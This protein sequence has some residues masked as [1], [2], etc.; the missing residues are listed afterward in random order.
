MTNK[1]KTFNNLIAGGIAGTISRTIVAPFD[2]VK[3][4]MQT[5][6][7]NSSFYNTFNSNI[8]NEGIKNLWKGNMLNCM[9]VFPYSALQFSTYDLCKKHLNK[10]NED[11]T[12]QERLLAGTLAGSIATTLTHPIDVVRHRLMCYDEIKT[13]RGAIKD[14]YKENGFKS[15]FKGYGSTML[16]LTPF[17]AINFATYDYLKSKYNNST[18]SISSIILTSSISSLTA[19][20]VCYPLDT[21]RRR[22]MSKD[23]LYKNS[24]DGLIKILSTEGVRSLY[25]GITVN[26][27][28]MI[29]NNCIRFI[30]Y[31][32][33]KNSNE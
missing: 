2:K 29:P 19:Q 4:L 18:N 26:M 20:S 21:I 31:E 6:T 32:S 3:I 23:F 24:L 33:I 12:I 11:I 1:E 13:S 22:M 16:G 5:N 10:K 25:S 7:N 28:K 30:V 17:I 9:R 14:L 8:K 27:T 15:A